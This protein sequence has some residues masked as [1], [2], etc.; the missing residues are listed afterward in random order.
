MK[1]LLNVIE[2]V[3]PN[4]EEGGKL[5]AF[6]PV[7]GALEHFFFAPADRTVCAP[8]IRDPIDLK[9]FMSMVIISLVPCVFAALYFFG[10]RFLAMII[11]SYAAGLTVEALF[12]IVRKEGINEGFF[13]TGILWPLILPPTFGLARG[14]LLFLHW[15]FRLPMSNRCLLTF[16]QT[17]SG[18]FLTVRFPSLASGTS[19]EHVIFLG[20]SCTFGFY[21]FQT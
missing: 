15:V 5:K 2:K 13:V 9:R 7:F 18:N 8:H 12:A 14:F 16:S 10:L 17:C 3:R 21:L 20:P 1:W 6:N 4:F 19:Q 11:V